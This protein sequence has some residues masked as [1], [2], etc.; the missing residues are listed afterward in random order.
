MTIAAT[1]PGFFAILAALPALAQ[2]LPG[3][4]KTTARALPAV[5]HF[6]FSAEIPTAFVDPDGTVRTLAP[7][8]PGAPI[9]AAVTPA[10]DPCPGA[11]ALAVETA[12][13]LILRMAKEEAFFPDFVLSVAG[14]ES[15]YVST[16]LSSKGAYGL[17]Q[18]TAATA[19]RFEVNLCDP[20]QNVRGGIRFLRVL[21]QRYRNPFFILAAWNAG[22]QALT[23]HGGI[24][25]FPETAR[26]IAAVMNDF[27]Q[28]PKIANGSQQNAAS[29][30]AEGTAARDHV[31]AHVPQRSD[32]HAVAEG[33]SGGFVLH[34]D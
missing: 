12:K 7:Q 8:G 13:V 1:I 16:A 21:H 28:W 26:F 27:Y 23:E 18:L 33:W 5:A 17:M 30:A 24:P 20:A 10:G 14:V 31:K 25:P 32:N 15:R 2:N 19:K 3:P 34:I 29:P 11:K 6:D 9:S 22:E 4:E